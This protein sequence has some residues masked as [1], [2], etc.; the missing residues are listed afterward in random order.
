MYMQRE[1]GGRG[2]KKKVSGGVSRQDRT[3]SGDQGDDGGAA[4]LDMYQGGRP[5]DSQTSKPKRSQ[6]CT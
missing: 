4:A 3:S 2:K 1:R 5:F 6:R